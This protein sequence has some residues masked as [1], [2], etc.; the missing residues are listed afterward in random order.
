ME[1][2]ITELQTRLSFQ[3]ET[4]EQISRTLVQQQ[5]ELHE[6]RQ[7]MQHLQKQILAVTPSDIDATHDEPPPHY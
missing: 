5:T 4:I 6:I 3:E 7:M 2:K 1:D